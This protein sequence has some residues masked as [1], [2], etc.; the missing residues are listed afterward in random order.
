MARKKQ[1]MDISD[2]R[3]WKHYGIVP[4]I[5]N[6]EKNGDVSS[7][8][9]S[10]S[11]VK[12]VKENGLKI[13]KYC[14]TM[15]LVEMGL[16]LTQVLTIIIIKQPDAWNIGTTIAAM[17]GI[18]VLVMALALGFSR[19]GDSRVKKWLAKS[20]YQDIDPPMKRELNLYRW[21]WKD[22]PI[23]FHYKNSNIV[24][25]L[26]VTQL[27]YFIQFTLQD[28]KAGEFVK[29]SGLV[30]WQVAKHEERDKPKR[31][32]WKRDRKGLFTM[33]YSTGV[34]CAG[35]QE[36]RVKVAIRSAVR[37]AFPGCKMDEVRGKGARKTLGYYYGEEIKNVFVIC[38]E[39]GMAELA[40]EHQP[41]HAME[42]DI[43]IGKVRETETLT[44][45]VDAGILHEHLE[46][47]LC[48]V[49]GIPMERL[50]TMKIVASQ[51]SIGSTII[52]DDHGD[53][54]TKGVPVYEAGLNCQLNPLVPAWYDGND[55]QGLY[56]ASDGHLE[57]LVNTMSLLLEWS[58]E[59]ESLFFN[60]YKTFYNAS[61]AK[62]TLPA[63]TGK[64]SLIDEMKFGNDRVS[65]VE[66]GVSQSVKRIF[67]SSSIWS[68]EDVP[69]F[70][71]DVL[72][73]GKMIFD[74]SNIHGLEKRAF[75][76]VLLVKVME[77]IRNERRRGN[78]QPVL[79]IIPEIDK[80]FHDQRENLENSFKRKIIK[81]IGSMIHAETS[82]MMSAQAIS[83]MP[84]TML[85]RM[86]AMVSFR[87]THFKDIND[88]I[89]LFNLEN[90]PVF[91]NRHHARQVDNLK[92]LKPGSAYMVRS[93]I[94]HPYEIKVDINEGIGLMGRQGMPGSEVYNPETVMV[95]GSQSLLRDILGKYAAVMDEVVAAL[96]RLKSTRDF[97]ITRRNYVDYWRSVLETALLEKDPGMG[98]A[99]AKRRSKEIAENLLD[100]LVRSGILLIDDYSST[101][102]RSDVKYK[103]TTFGINLLEND[104]DMLNRK[105]Q[106]AAKQREDAGPGY[107]DAYF[108]EF[109][110]PPGWIF[111]EEEDQ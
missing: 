71:P 16:C 18:L 100:K 77:Y 78:H 20:G 97:G 73:A 23:Y 14:K 99:D 80:L 104:T 85:Q 92:T 58:M 65:H 39:L 8:D 67:S 56:Q 10:K 106:D 47:G 48:I 105:P 57:N 55:V 59:H 50:A 107:D 28:V 88:T 86:A 30:E 4:A 98:V 32:E 93:D 79:V 87:Q 35:D 91:G 96:A 33:H 54:I 75:K 22:M 12:E 60:R 41:V 21:D 90:E 5:G 63:L 84:P 69:R 31:D 49:G 6:N 52:I 43:V 26:N 68:S 102:L 94:S 64:D 101:G 19:L 36:E 37:A 89:S 72:N 81:F 66:R 9:D 34:L 3:H 38:K 1:I 27:P 24:G 53:F 74:L 15:V 7:K 11:Q 17:A 111:E 83:T 44:S 13:K 40:R 76:A 62:G 95:K 2:P 29:K 110:P 45:N 25:G 108:N 51:E 109:Y 70:K 46:G 61:A 103:L 42:N 82:L